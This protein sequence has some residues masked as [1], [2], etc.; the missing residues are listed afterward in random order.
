MLTPLYAASAHD[1]VLH[2]LVHAHYLLAGC[3]FAWAI[4]GPD[5]APRR[6]AMATRIVV[7]VIA[8]AAHAYL[9]KRLYAGADWLPPGL[10]GRDPQSWQAAAE[11]MYYGG[12]IADLL[13]ATALFA[14]W[15][16]R[17]RST[18]RGRSLGTDVV[19]AQVPAA[20]P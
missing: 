5:P 19:G 12:S 1:P 20:R 4:A 8:S 16:R 3:M 18:A 15:Y 13:L 7:L 9:A 11:L 2:H 14:T 6:P 10:P 17:R